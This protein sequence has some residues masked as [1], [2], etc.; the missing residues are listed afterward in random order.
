MKKAVVLLFIFLT[1]VSIGY[2]LRVSPGA[3]CA[4]GVEIGKDVDTGLDVVIDNDSN[5]DLLF[6]L[7]P[8]KPA[9]PSDESMKGYQP[10]PDSSWLYL[11]KNEVF[12]PAKGQG[13][14]RLHFK[15]PAED[16]YYNQHWI[17]SYR[18]T[19]ATKAFFKPA[20]ATTYV[21]ETKSKRDPKERPFS[22]LGVA[23]SVVNLPIGG[24][25]VF[26]VYN[27]TGEKRN[28]NLWVFIPKD[29]PGRLTITKSRNFEWLENSSWLKIEKNKFTLDK[30]M[31]FEAK[32][33][34][35][36]PKGSDSKK[37]EAIV[38]AKSNK[39]ETNFVRV[40]IE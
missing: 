39:G 4:Q 23:P 32:L 38:F 34:A 33:I 26:K 40:W 27:N 9:M 36:L 15:I 11:D 18:V 22:S 37:R 3:F 20:V 17:A 1:F 24:S 31:V 2:A 21:I 19:P 25:A 5:K 16:K 12:A 30:G 6:S 10:I 35:N 7:T 13:K 8:A 14:A 29:K 28:Y